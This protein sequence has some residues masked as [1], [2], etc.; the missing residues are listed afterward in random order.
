[1]NI[2]LVEDNPADMRMLKD[3]LEEKPSSPVLNWVTDGYE[4]LDYVCQRNEYREVTR[5]DVILLDLG[6]PRISGYDVLKKLKEEP[7]YAGIPIIIL[8]TSRN[9]FD[10]S[11]CEALG[12]DVFVSKPHSLK[13][14]EAL[15][16][17]LISQEFPRLMEDNKQ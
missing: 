15:V 2:L 7:T 4:A 8:T 9:P 13:G 17:Q 16:Q 1:M 6:L 5:P 12:A 10:R 14:Y 3:L 11:Q